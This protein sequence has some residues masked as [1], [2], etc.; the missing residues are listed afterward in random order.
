[1]SAGESA[2]KASEA[3]V[4]VSDAYEAAAKQ[5]M[6][7][8]ACAAAAAAAEKAVKAGGSLKEAAE[9]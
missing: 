8:A 9:A 3:A 6:P 4:S 1:M 5:G 7:A 2:S